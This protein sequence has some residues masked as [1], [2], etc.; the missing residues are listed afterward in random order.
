MVVI[1][2]LSRQ[3]YTFGAVTFSLLGTK[4]YGP[5]TKPP[6]EYRS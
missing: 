5:P 1:S 2:P 6:L 4:S 3:A